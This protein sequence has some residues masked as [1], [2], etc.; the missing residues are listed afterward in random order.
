MELRVE[1]LSVQS[2]VSVDTIRYYQ[3]KGLLDPPRREGRI[4]W[5]DVRHLERLA[6]I[7]S[8]QKRG[9]TLATIARLVT[10]ELDAADEALLGE[11]SG[12]RRES[13]RTVQQ[14]G[15]PDDPG[16][17]YSVGGG[18]S[19]AGSPGTHTDTYTLSELAIETGVPLALLKAI[20]AE[21]LL[22]A[23]RVN[24]QERYTSEDV[25]ASKAGLLL[26][27][28][29]I[30]L[31][32]L[33]DLARRHHE[34]TEA[35]A[36]EAVAI[37][38]VYVRGPLRDRQ[39]GNADGA[40]S[41]GKSADESADESADGPADRDTDRLLQAYSEILPAVKTLVGHH[42]TRT[43][44]KAALDHVE[45]VGSDAE[46]RAISDHARLSDSGIL[47]ILDAESP[48]PSR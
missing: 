35:V 36:R 34:A 29:G 30:P 20:E 14:A 31:S 24:G 48:A 41:D 11:L 33:L 40:Q 27:E 4:A 12:V 7:R 37:F 28:W 13:G 45:L 18:G 44:V 38:S 32:A 23:R 43:L 42:F 26:L 22:I 17:R 1:Q 10:G 15:R 9:F 6:R 19:G 39:R 3:S 25:A 21:G 46:R 16:S 5:Y 2:D 47:D 8:L